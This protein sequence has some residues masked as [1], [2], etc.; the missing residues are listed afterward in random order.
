MLDLGAQ[1]ILFPW[2]NDAEQAAAAVAS[3]RYPPHGVRGVMSLARMNQYGTNGPAYFHECDAQICRIV[4]VETVE[5]VS[6]I[7][8]IAAVDGVDALFV[9]PSDLAASMG[10]IG[11][12]AHPEVRAAIADAVRRIAASGKAGGFLSANPDDCKWVLEL[13]VDFVAV[14]SDVAL[15]TNLCRAK[16]EEFHAFAAGLKPK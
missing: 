16:A 11:N 14:G 1:S 13:G 8:A 10:H 15:L 4:Q 5:A 6:N 2:I 9:G 12:P 7:E 3:T